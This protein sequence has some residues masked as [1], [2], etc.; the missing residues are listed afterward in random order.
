VNKY[1]KE[2]DVMPFLD[3]DV[4]VK[5]F[6]DKQWTLVEQLRYQGNQDLF[7]VPPEFETDFASVPRV[8]VWFLP[9]YGRYTKAAILHDYLCKKGEV[10]RSDA[11]GI[12]RRAMMELEVAF[13]RRWIMW[14]AVR[15]GGGIQEL[16]RPG[17]WQ[18]L[19][20]LLIGVPALALVAVPAVAVVA[21]L[22]LFWLIELVFYAGL[23]LV[24]GRKPPSERKPVNPPQL[25]LKT[26]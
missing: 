12:F 17:L 24:S 14:A 2:C 10:K 19:L 5:T 21:A 9:R 25:L 7:T 18:F 6:G 23:K 20:V 16:L 11:D 1:G 15:V 22:A 26:S 4:V 3:N 13:L 8:F